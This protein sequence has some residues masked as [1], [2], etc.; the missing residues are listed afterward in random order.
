VVQHCSYYGSV[1]RA[2][3]HAYTKVEFK[4]CA[5]RTPPWFKISINLP[6]LTYSSVLPANAP[7]L[8]IRDIAKVNDLMLNIFKGL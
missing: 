2:L 6:L 3:S 1:S 4:V 5:N 7:F 8:V